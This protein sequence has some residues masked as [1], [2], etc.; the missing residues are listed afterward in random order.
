MCQRRVLY[1]LI[2]RD[3]VLDLI[4]P[5]PPF[6]FRA[7]R[8]ELDN[9]NISS[10]SVVVAAPAKWSLARVNGSSNNMDASGCGCLV[11]K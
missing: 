6:S 10:L 9:T 2:I 1:G 11:P 3:L 8:D 7:P 5:L 4:F